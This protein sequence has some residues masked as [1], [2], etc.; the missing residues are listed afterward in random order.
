MDVCADA[1]AATGAFC[2]I[3]CSAAVAIHREGP[4]SGDDDVV[5]VVATRSALNIFEADVV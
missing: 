3:C 5:E 1:V 2:C 4:A